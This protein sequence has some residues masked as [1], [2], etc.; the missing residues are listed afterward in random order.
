MDFSQRETDI[1]RRLSTRLRKLVENC[2]YTDAE[3]EVR[4]Q[5]VCSCYNSKLREKFLRTPDL[6]VK[7][8]IEVGQLYEHSK[9]QAT[10]IGSIQEEILQVNPSSRLRAQSGKSNFSSFQYR[11]RHSKSVAP[12][13]KANKSCYKCGRTFTPDHRKNCPAVGKIC[14]FCGITGHLQTVCMKKLQVNEVV[15]YDE[16]ESSEEDVSPAIHFTQKQPPPNFYKGVFNFSINKPQRCQTAPRFT[17]LLNNTRVSLIG[18]TGASCSCLNY[19]TFKY[20]QRSNPTVQLQK[21]KSKIF[22]FGNNRVQPMEKFVGIFE[23]NKKF[24]TDTIY[25]MHDNSFEN[26]MSKDVCVN[27]K[28]IRIQGENNQNINLIQNNFVSK[29]PVA[30]QGLLEKYIDIFQGDG[31]L[32]NYEH[33][34]YV[35]PTVKPIAQRLR[36]YP[37]HLRD[38]INADLD[39]LLERDYI[40]EVNCPSE[41]ISNMVVVPKKMAP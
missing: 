27:L 31:L 39:D 28:F 6:C 5:F 16:C 37:Y 19:T 9:Q 23:G 22:S 13:S 15:H 20:I 11:G 21:T 30:V 41:W 35:D 7:K 4:D 14:N 2:E 38:K 17:V 8:I 12:Q 25:V 24:C 33:K 3:T 32:K 40:K 29:Q 10:E 1:R 18:D 26:I 34:I 36:R